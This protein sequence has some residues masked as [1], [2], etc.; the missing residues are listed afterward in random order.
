MQHP[1]VISFLISE[2]PVVPDKSRFGQTCSQSACG[3]KHFKTEIEFQNFVPMPCREWFVITTCDHD[4][5]HRNSANA[6]YWMNR[7]HDL[8]HSNSAN[9]DK[10]KAE[11]I[12]KLYVLLSSR[13]LVRF[14]DKPSSTL[15]S[16]S[17]WSRSWFNYV[18]SR[19]SIW[20]TDSIDSLLLAAAM[21]QS[22]KVAPL[23][24]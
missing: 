9:A 2:L 11:S 12:C 21:K 19:A 24:L 13:D 22:Y 15:N 8:T 23:T 14:H 20:S 18:L 3:K 17:S 16:S 4:I 10:W 1:V 6:L 7:D 5:T